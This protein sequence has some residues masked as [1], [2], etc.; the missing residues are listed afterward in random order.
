VA[1]HQCSH[2]AAFSGLESYVRTEAP[3]LLQQELESF[4]PELKTIINE[5][6]REKL[7][8]LLPKLQLKLINNF[9]LGKPAPHQP[10]SAVPDDQA[11]PRDQGH[12]EV[13]ESILAQ[14]L[15]FLDPLSFLENM[16]W[17]NFG[18]LDFEVAILPPH[19][20]A[21]ES[22]TPG[23]L[24]AGLQS[25][26]DEGQLYFGAPLKGTQ[27][28][29]YFISLL[30]TVTESESSGTTP[31]EMRLFSGHGEPFDF[32]SRGLDVEASLG[33]FA[34]GKAHE[35]QDGCS[36]GTGTRLRP[37]GGFE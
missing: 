22:S 10:Q 28:S 13:P 27:D 11:Q 12:A 3:Q 35:P 19:Q 2:Q 25:L 31:P 33:E 6:L 15:D 32:G 9:R 16:D 1:E 18:K 23:S 14:P 36:S 37:A 5:K 20:Q 29:G 4:E 30:G 8:E 24:A 21:G 7:S 26:G 17:G 34:T